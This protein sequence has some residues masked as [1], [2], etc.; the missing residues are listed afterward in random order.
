MN[1][2]SDTRRVK[3]ARVYRRLWRENSSV[4]LH[5][6]GCWGT[7]SSSPPPRVETLVELLEDA[8]VVLDVLDD[9]E[10]ARDVELVLEGEGPGVGLEHRGA[11][12]SRRSQRGA[13][14]QQL[15]DRHPNIRPSASDRCAH[16]S[17]TGTD[18]EERSGRR[19]VP[20]ESPQDQRVTGV[21]PEMP[22]LCLEQ[23]PMLADDESLVR[24]RQG[25]RQV[26]YAA[27]HGRRPAAC[28]AEPGG[29]G[30][31]AITDRAPSH[32][33]LTP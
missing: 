16:V 29:R 26:R 21:E 27:A 14:G 20:L 33:S 28:G 25:R 23:W 30:D 13:I 6:Q 3:A 24:R 2:V 1:P 10:R 15:S 4:R 5:S 11:P 7:V 32:R 19:K 22:R 17:G 18:F 31:D 9:V 12:E 8:R